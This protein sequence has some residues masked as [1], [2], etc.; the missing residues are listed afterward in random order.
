MKIPAVPIIN[1]IDNSNLAK[2]SAVT[3]EAIGYTGMSCCY[4]MLVS[5]RPLLFPTLDYTGATTAQA[6]EEEAGEA[7]FNQLQI[8]R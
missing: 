5:D 4:D 6:I 1:S 3:V 7:T 2:E 8:A